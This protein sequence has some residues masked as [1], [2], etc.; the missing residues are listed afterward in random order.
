[1]IEERRARSLRAPRAVTSSYLR[2]AALHYLQQRSASRAMV[3]TTLVRRAKSRLQVR[4]LEPET[5]A[6]IDAAL[7]GLVADKLIDDVVFARG[8]TATLQNKGLPMRRIAQGL[9][10]KGVDAAIVDATLADGIDDLAQ[11]RRYA[12]RRR[13]GHWSRKVDSPDQRRKDL[14]AMARAG[15]SYATASRSL[16]GDDET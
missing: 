3:R 10:L 7:D 15:F 12:E 8:R 6:L 5:T 16:T 4:A 13:L 2:N 1:M 9:K 14:A 11:A